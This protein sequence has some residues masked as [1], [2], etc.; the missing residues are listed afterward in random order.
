MDLDKIFLVHH[1]RE[2]DDGTDEVKFIGAFSSIEIANQAVKKIENEPGFRDFPDGF[3]VEPHT[4]NRI[5]WL[6]G[7]EYE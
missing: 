5:G 7:F 1:V 2:L 4:L 6:E 3:I